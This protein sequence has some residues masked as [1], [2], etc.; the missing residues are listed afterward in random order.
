MEVVPTICLGIHDL[1][2]ILWTEKSDQVQ[3]CMGGNGLSRPRKVSG[4]V[5]Q[6]IKLGQ[7]SMILSNTGNEDA[8][9]LSKGI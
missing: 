8:H 7:Q 5:G 9:P 2:V 3:I 4:K 1:N 6:L